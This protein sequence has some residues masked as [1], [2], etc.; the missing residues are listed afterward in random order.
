MMVFHFYRLFKI[1]DLFDRARAANRLLA[2]HTYVLVNVQKVKFIEFLRWHANF[3][4]RVLPR[5]VSVTI[6]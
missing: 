1:V 6:S 3:F 5:L 4:E 2:V